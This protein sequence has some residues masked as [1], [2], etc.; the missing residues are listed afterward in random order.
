MFKIIQN[1][2]LTQISNK[3]PFRVVS[4]LQ[5]IKNR[6]VI[7]HARGTDTLAPGSA[8]FTTT[9]QKQTTPCTRA[10]SARFQKTGKARRKRSTV[11][12]RVKEAEVLCVR[13]CEVKK[14]FPLQLTRPHFYVNSASIFR[15]LGY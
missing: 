4:R 11:T 12:F 1:D 9:V 7:P 13:A 15:L 6:A 14:K 2:E 8:C 3:N 5:R 10:D